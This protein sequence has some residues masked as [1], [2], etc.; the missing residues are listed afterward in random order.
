MRE[1]RI[2]EIEIR[3]PTKAAAGLGETGELIDI[4]TMEALALDGGQ[5]ELALGRIA[6]NIGLLQP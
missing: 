1:Q 6:D 4:E 5:N 2:D 3:M